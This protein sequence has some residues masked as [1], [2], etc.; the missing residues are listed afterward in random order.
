MFNK[1][2]IKFFL[3][4]LCIFPLCADSISDY[5][6]ISL[7]G[8]GEKAEVYL[9]R[10]YLGNLKALKKMHSKDHFVGIYPLQYLNA[11]FK[12]DGSS[13]LAQKEFSVSLQ[14]DHP[15]IIKIEG[16]FKDSDAEGRVHSYLVMEYVNGKTLKEIP[17]GSLDSEIAFRGLLQIIDAVSYGFGHFYIHNDLYSSNIMFDESLQIKLID[18]ESFDELPVKD[19]GGDDR[20]NREYAESLLITFWDV[21]ACGD[22]DDKELNNIYSKMVELLNSSTYADQIEDIIC[23]DSFYFFTTFLDELS[24]QIEIARSRNQESL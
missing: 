15:N 18:L 8:E 22:I 17:R 2:I 5:E 10:D 19:I 20:T 24:E 21:L 6:I 12:S 1:I 16:I 23:F 14:L 7:I 11:I 13:L 3:I 4:C 9:V